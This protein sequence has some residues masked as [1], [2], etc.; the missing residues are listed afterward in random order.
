MD[1]E[2]NSGGIADVENAIPSAK[3]MFLS[4]PLSSQSRTFSTRS[5]KLISSPQPAANTGE[6]CIHL[7][8]IKAYMGRCK[9]RP[10]SFCGTRFIPP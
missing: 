10:R 2:P 5:A 1:P 8:E 3:K 6:Y 4:Q 7:W 9:S